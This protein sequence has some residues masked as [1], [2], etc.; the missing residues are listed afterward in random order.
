MKETNVLYKIY[1]I[2]CND[3]GA[4]N[5]SPKLIVVIRLLTLT[6][7]IYSLISSGMCLFASQKGGMIFCLISA[8]LFISIF[9]LSY[10]SRTFVAY[11]ILN[12]YIL[13][14]IIFNIIMFGWDNGV[15]HFIIV[16]LGA[17]FFAKYK[18]ETI[19]VSYAL[20]LCILRICLFF[21]CQ[22]NVPRINLSTDENSLFQI[23][24][25][26]AIFWSISLIAYVFSTDSQSMEGK[27]IEYNE[28]LQKQAS[29]DPLTGL[30]NRRRTMDYLEK[31]LRA[32]AQPISICMCDIDFFKR[33]NDTY[34]HDV[35]DIV[36]KG[37]S[38]IFC[39]EL[40]DGTFISRWGGEDF[41]LIGCAGARNSF[42]R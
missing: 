32:P 15:Q 17:C 26:I 33:V 9:V 35:G 20:A 6:M 31:L 23:I 4:Q 22:N 36:L 34:G 7:V 12:I 11:C 5:E 18:H 24:N 8:V 1:Q 38:E 27:L 2:I 16:L 37:V 39:K 21:Y 14:W 3:T 13:I 10:Y 29:I 28:Q 25:T 41:L 40:P 42:S 30:Y 19:K